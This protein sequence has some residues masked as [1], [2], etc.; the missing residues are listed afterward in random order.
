MQR[1]SNTLGISFSVSSSPSLSTSL[2]L[3]SFLPPSYSHTHNS[4]DKIKFMASTKLCHGKSTVQLCL[5]LLPSPSSHTHT[6]THRILLYFICCFTALVPQQLIEFR[7][8]ILPYLIFRIHIP[9]PHGWNL[10][11]S[12]CSELLLYTTINA[13]TIYLFLYRPFVWPNTPP[14][15]LQR[16]MW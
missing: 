7:Y 11:L 14:G 2:P 3:A 9:K 10:T 1:H 16:F 5:Y 6:H 4:E 12:L 13:V 15:Q 8:Y